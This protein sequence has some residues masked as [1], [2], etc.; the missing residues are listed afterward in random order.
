[1]DQKPAPEVSMAYKV[2]KKTTTRVVVN[3]RDEASPLY[4]PA[5]LHDEVSAGG[6]YMDVD[7]VEN[8]QL[9]V[10]GEYSEVE[11]RQRM[12][13]EPQT[14]EGAAVGLKFNF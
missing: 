7:L 11:N 2:T 8:I 14:S 12:Y 10:G 4:R 1:M 5:E 9:T 6:M 13:G 3:P